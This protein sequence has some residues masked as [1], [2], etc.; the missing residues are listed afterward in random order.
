VKKKL[1]V[2]RAKLIVLRGK[3][4]SFENWAKAKSLSWAK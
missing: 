3:K 2:Q 4:V 1:I